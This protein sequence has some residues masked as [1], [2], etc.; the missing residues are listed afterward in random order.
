M[1]VV[2]RKGRCCRTQWERGNQQFSIHTSACSGTRAFFKNG[3]TGLCGQKV[4]KTSLVTGKSKSR[5]EEPTKATIKTNKNSN[6]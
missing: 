6:A 5:N 1:L 2:A 4:A 3:I